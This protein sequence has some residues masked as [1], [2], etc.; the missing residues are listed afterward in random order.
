MQG[1]ADIENMSF[2]RINAI[3]N[4][5]DSD[6]LVDQATDDLDEASK[7]AHQEEEY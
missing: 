7:S 4:E 6:I 1:E 2:S 3:V 5:E